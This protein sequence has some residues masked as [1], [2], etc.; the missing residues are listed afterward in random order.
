MIGPCQVMEHHL[1]V[2]KS[3]ACS[4]P[5]KPQVYTTGTHSGGL[6]WSVVGRPPQNQGQIVKQNAL[7]RVI[8]GSREVSSSFEV[9]NTI[10]SWHYEVLCLT[11]QIQDRLSSLAL[12]WQACLNHINHSNLWKIGRN[13]MTIWKFSCGV[14]GECVI[15]G[16]CISLLSWRHTV[17]VQFI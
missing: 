7:S 17:K 11:V 12:V 1:S 3:S 16:V 8:G 13:F 10:T 5:W 4:V 15:H 14:H 6:G 2:F 9:S